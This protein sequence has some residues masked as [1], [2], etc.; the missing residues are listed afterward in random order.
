M[1]NLM[2]KYFRNTDQLEHIWELCATYFFEND[3]LQAHVK[4]KKTFK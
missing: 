4:G 2:P 1:E 3:V